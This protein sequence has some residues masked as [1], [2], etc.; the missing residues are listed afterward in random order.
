MAVVK[1]FGGDVVVVDVVDVDV[2]DGG[3]GDGDGDGDGGGGASL[4]RVFMSL[5]CTNQY[6]ERL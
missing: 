5:F 6:R 4:L 1:L 2:D 3:E